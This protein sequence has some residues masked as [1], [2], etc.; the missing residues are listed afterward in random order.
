MIPFLLQWSFLAPFGIAPAYSE[1]V[2]ATKQ[3]QQIPF[4]CSINFC[5]WIRIGNKCGAFVVDMY[6]KQNAPGTLLLYPEE[7]AFLEHIWECLRGSPDF[8]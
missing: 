1:H 6:V 3:V 8:A 5:I 4:H 7:T 2:D